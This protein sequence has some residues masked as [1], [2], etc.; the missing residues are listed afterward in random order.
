MCTLRSG[1]HAATHPVP[2][3][4]TTAGFM[5]AMPDPISISSSPAPAA[6]V[7]RSGFLWDARAALGVRKFHLCRLERRRVE[8][9]PGHSDKHKATDVSTC[10]ASVSP[11]GG[12]V[13]KMALALHWRCR[14]RCL[15]ASSAPSRCRRR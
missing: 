5:P 8:L 7:L 15:T 4:I 2:L 1:G 3:S 9:V 13:S 6:M 14:L 10:L 12:G 11:Q